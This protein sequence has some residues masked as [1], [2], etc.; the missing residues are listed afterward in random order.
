MWK[1][2]LWNVSG[3]TSSQARVTMNEL[4]HCAATRQLASISKICFLAATKQGRCVTIYL[5]FLHTYSP[6]TASSRFIWTKA[7]LASPMCQYI[8][9]PHSKQMLV[10]AFFFHEIGGTLI[11]CNMLSYSG[12]GEPDPCWTS[13]DQISEKDPMITAYHIHIGDRNAV[14]V[15]LAVKTQDQAADRI[16]Q[17]PQ[18][19]GHSF[20]VSVWGIVLTRRWQHDHNIFVPGRPDS[21]SWA[22]DL[23]DSFA[24]ASASPF[25][26]PKHGT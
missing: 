19:P 13:S 24:Y 9:I 7:R 18:S 10:I 14:R 2:W 16:R 23:W 4:K 26:V 5:N 22:N 6:M 20:E 17:L 3:R 1:T 15:V 11:C 8:D 12:N 21:K 25:A